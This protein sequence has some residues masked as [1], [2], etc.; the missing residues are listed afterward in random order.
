MGEGR[1]DK[2][3]AD[4]TGCLKSNQHLLVLHGR[5]ER[6]RASLNLLPAFRRLFNPSELQ[7]VV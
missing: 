3:Q 1:D 4:Q 2:S 5:G 7:G 6:S